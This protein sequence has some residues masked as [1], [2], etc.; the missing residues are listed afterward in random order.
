MSNPASLVHFE[1]VS[2]NYGDGPDVLRDVTFSLPEGSFHFLTGGSG[3]GKSSLIRL[4]YQGY[5]N[6]RGHITMF[7]RDAAKLDSLQLP[8]FRQQIGVV[9]QYFNLLNH[10]SVV[11]NVALPLCI[12]G[13]SL[14]QSRIYAS[15]IL[16]WVGLG[17]Y[18]EEYP[19]SLSGGEQQRISLA[20]AVIGNPRLILADE[21]T[22]SV[23]DGI[24]VRMLHLFQ[25]LHKMGTTIV[26]ATHNRDLIGEYVY[27]V[28]HIENQQLVLLEPTLER[29]VAD[30]A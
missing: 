11:D 22:G 1:R 15:E 14:K 28:L 24:A 6:Y 23:D 13:V 8:E 29:E 18:L 17:R 10:I 27:P 16:N 30:C 25:Q 4:M 2:M 19:G 12:R 5:R 26:L 20:R 7:G 21:P 9:F 3:A